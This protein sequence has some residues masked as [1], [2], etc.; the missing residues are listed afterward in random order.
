MVKV[1]CNAE[2]IVDKMVDFMASTQAFMEYLH[3][4]PEIEKVLSEVPEN[5][6]P[7]FYNRLEHYRHV[8]RQH[9]EDAE[10]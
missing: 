9:K 10:K 5:R 1:G 8:Y 7:F 6:K 4:A 2:R 3:R